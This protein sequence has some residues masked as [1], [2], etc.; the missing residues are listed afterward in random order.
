MLMTDLR[1]PDVNRVWLAAGVGRRTVFNIVEPAGH[2]HQPKQDR[3]SPSLTAN[4]CSILD[5]KY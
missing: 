1:L 2:L 5:E 3:A 4:F